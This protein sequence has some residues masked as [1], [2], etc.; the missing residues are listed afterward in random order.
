MAGVRRSLFGLVE[1]I[2]GVVSSVKPSF[3]GIV[4]VERVVPSVPFLDC[5]K[6]VM[7]LGDDIYTIDNEVVGNMHQTSLF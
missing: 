5:T 1:T 2:H 7:I 4:W 6:L 3:G